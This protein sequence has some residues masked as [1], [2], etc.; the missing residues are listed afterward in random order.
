MEVRKACGDETSGMFVWSMHLLAEIYRQQGEYE[1]AI[2]LCK[3]G[4]NI[5]ELRVGAQHPSYANA[6]EKLGLI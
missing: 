1:K 3:E 6:L 5:M 2:D 4:A